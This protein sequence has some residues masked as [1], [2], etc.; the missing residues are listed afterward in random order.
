MEQIT[1]ESPE[2][3]REHYLRAMIEIKAD[4]YLRVLQKTPEGR[5][6]LLSLLKKQRAQTE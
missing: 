5:Q 1:P 4:E 3:L 6:H 2:V